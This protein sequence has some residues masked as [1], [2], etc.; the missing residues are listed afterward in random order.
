VI[1]YGPAGPSL[2]TCSGTERDDNMKGDSG[3]N[4][5]YGLEGDDLLSGGAGN[6][7]LHDG[8]GND[9]LTGG[10]GDDILFG[11][12]GEDSF[13]CGQGNDLLN[14]SIIVFVKTEVG[15]TILHLWNLVQM[16]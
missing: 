6:Y 11:S 13:E 15:K 7:D 4:S 8:P 1:S 12:P 3:G 5:I 9:K 16:T 14:Y 10:S 2:D